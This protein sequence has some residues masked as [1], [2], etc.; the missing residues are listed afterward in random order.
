MLNSIKKILTQEIGAREKAAVAPEHIFLLDL[1]RK[2]EYLLDLRAI[3]RTPGARRALPRLHRLETTIT[4]NDQRIRIPH[5]AMPD[6]VRELVSVERRIPDNSPLRELLEAVPGLAQSIRVD[7]TPTSVLMGAHETVP[8]ELNTREMNAAAR[9]IGEALAQP[10]PDGEPSTKP[11]A[12][13]TPRKPIVKPLGDTQKTAQPSSTTPP[14]VMVMD[15]ANPTAPVFGNTVMGVSEQQRFL[16]ESGAQFEATVLRTADL[17]DG[18]LA[19][20]FDLCIMSGEHE[21]VID[22]LL[23][24][25]AEQPSAWGWSR[26]LAAAEKAKKMEFDVWCS[27]FRSW[28]ARAHPELL[29]DMTGETKEELR[30]GVRRAGL[31]DLERKELKR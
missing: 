18:D 25:V 10:V 8:G 11:A 4:R 6:L 19:A 5:E 24:R 26:L 16:Q 30:F 2:K 22:S 14:G 15:T 20:Y 28:V 21:K 23:P 7:P 1:E 31:H 27:N 13:T 12:Q 9:K 17:A 3:L 29:P